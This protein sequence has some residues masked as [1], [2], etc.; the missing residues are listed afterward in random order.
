MRCARIAGMIKEEIKIGSL[1]EMG[2][3][4]Q[5][6]VNGLA[7][8]PEGAVVIGLYGDLGAGKT[9]FVKGVARALSV[10]EVVASPTFAIE[11]IYKIPEG[12]MFRYLIHIDAYRLEGGSELIALGWKDIVKDPQNIIIIEWAERVEELLPGSTKKIHF[13]HLDETT[14]GVSVK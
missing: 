9:V 10:S 11:K 2:K 1:E 5:S 4:A 6:F 8:A 14:R 3:T 7:P 13:S 12:K